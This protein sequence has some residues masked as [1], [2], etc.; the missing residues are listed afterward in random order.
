MN[1]Q[2]KSKLQL[3]K[4]LEDLR[5]QIA[6]FE[7]LVNQKKQV[8]KALEKSQE[9]YHRVFD[10]AISPIYVFDDKKG[11]I[12]SNQAGL[13]LLG[14]SRDE[15]LKLAIHDVDADPQVVLPAHKQLLQGHDLAN[16]EHQLK[17]K[18]G[19]I[20]TII[21]NSIPLKN[22]AGNIIGM[23]SILIDIT[24][25]KNMEEKLQ[26]LSEHD[27]LT[28]LNNRKILEQQ[29]IYEIN[30]AIRYKH[31]LSVL[32]LDLDHFKLINDAYGHQAGDTVL[33]NFA[34]LL[35]SSIRKTD[36]AARYGGEEFVI[37]LPETSLSKAEE[38]AKQLCI[39][40]ATHLNFIENNKIKVTTSIGVCSFSEHGESWEELL[41][42]ADS[43]MYS[44]KDSGR[45][46]VRV[47]KNAS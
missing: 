5:R 7:I 33:H 8:E 22:A 31:A 30:R 38:L 21:N 2:E 25:R 37:I 39:Q 28:G 6:D 29:L 11:F 12:D 35:K 40:A 13:D 18:D 46:C 23:Q 17:T 24:E 1:D 34:K 45:N 27:P 47:A 16:Y 10:N 4:E 20:I 43:A 42:A 41:H 15:L 36:Y 3:I 32:M 19:K 9:K 14:Y 26:Y 44:A